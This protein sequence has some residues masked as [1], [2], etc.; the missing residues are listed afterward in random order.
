[1]AS[2]KVESVVRVLEDNRERGAK[3][4]HVVAIADLDPTSGRS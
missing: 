1:V 2:L 3:W 4:S